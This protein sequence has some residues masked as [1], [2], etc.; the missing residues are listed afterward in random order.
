MKELNTIPE[1][2]K[3][4]SPDEIKKHRNEISILLEIGMSSVTYGALK[5]IVKGST[6]VASKAAKSPAMPLPTIM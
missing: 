6:K 2:Q 1:T 5:G 3:I 4:V